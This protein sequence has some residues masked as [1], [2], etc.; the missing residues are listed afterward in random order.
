VKEAPPAS[1][2]RV[3]PHALVEAFYSDLKAAKPLASLPAVHCAKSVSF[4]SSMSVAFGQDQT[5]DLSCG[6]G[7]NPVMRDLIRDTRQIIALVRAN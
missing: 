4:G 5:P 1:I 2:R 6:D 7:G 3:L